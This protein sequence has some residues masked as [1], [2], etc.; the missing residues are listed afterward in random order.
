M[1]RRGGQKIDGDRAQDTPDN[2][3]HAY[4]AGVKIAFGKDQRIPSLRTDGIYLYD[5]S[6]NAAIEAIKAAT[7]TLPS[8]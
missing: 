3:G 5:R 1:F 2:I 7:I 4:K 8:F 6:R